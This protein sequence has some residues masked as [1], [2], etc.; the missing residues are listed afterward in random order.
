MLFTTIGIQADG[1]FSARLVI[2]GELTIG[3]LV[4][5]NMLSGRVSGPILR[6]AQAD[7]LN[8][9]VEPAAGAGR[10]TLT[11]LRG[12]VQFEHIA[13][14]YRADGPAAVSDLTL[15]VPQGQLVGVVGASVTS[16]SMALW[17][18]TRSVVNPSCRRS[19]PNAMVVF[20]C[21]AERRGGI[22]SCPGSAPAD[23][24]ALASASRM[25]GP[26]YISRDFLL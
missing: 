26:R 9:P 6:L 10:G 11:E 18:L 13:F 2:D 1:W 4:A 16:R 24:P 3:Q 7:I 21:A 14:R 17:A 8:T 19:P 5:F 23:S 12:T 20:R 25:R 15:A 22:R